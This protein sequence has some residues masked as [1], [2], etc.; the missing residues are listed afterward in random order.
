VVVSR[1]FSS[2]FEV[3]MMVVGVPA[4]AGS[5]TAPLAP[6]APLVHRTKVSFSPPP[7]RRRPCHYFRRPSS[8]TDRKRPG[9]IYILANRRKEDLKINQKQKIYE[10]RSQ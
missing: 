3:V 5:S 4:A 2:C 6:L 8:A 9:R 7:R 1:R 10:Q